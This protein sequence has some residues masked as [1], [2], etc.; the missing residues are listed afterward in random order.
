MHEQLFI[1]TKL[2]VGYNNRSDTY[3]KKLAYVIYYDQK[4]ILRQEKSW[5]G[6]RDKKIEPNDYTNE[7]T[8]GFVLNK[9]VG[10]QR[11]SYGWNARNEYV[12]VFDPRGFEFEIS[13][14]NLLFILAECDSFK[15]KG[16]SGQFV[17]AWSGSSL[18]LLPVSSHEY[19]AS[20]EFTGLQ[21]CKVSAKDLVIGGTYETKTRET[22]IYLG[23]FNAFNYY[24]WRSIDEAE[25]AINMKH[26]VF[27]RIYNGRKIISYTKNVSN[28]A[29]EISKDPVENL[30]ELIDDVL[31]DSSFGKITN[32]DTRPAIIKPEVH[33]QKGDTYNVDGYLFKYDGETYQMYKMT[34]DELDSYKYSDKNDRYYSYRSYKRSKKY[35]LQQYKKFKIVD[36][37]III[38]D[39]T[40]R[41]I[42][43]FT[44]NEINEMPFLDLIFNTKNAKHKLRL[45]NIN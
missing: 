36:G 10:G 41:E 6:W 30:A 3:T 38:I 33:T 18:V 27:I 12:R 7:P 37:E 28:I 29:K 23:K 20:T 16:L 26:H 22:E 43:V 1:P 4:N 40:P 11:E 21:S 8:E 14:A 15:G 25:M 13:I 17:Y 44:E 32:V 31:N 42:Q 34:F 9:G 35:S 5:E 39:N 45:T 24:D 19:K 2:K